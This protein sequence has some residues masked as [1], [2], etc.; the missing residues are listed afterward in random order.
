M[1]LLIT[2]T[3]RPLTVAPHHNFATFAEAWTYAVNTINAVQRAARPVYSN[4]K[5]W[6]VKVTN[7]INKH[8]Q[9]KQGQQKNCLQNWLITAN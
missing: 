7:A 9:K 5:S 1:S 3:P 6:Q 4:A 8:W 2:E